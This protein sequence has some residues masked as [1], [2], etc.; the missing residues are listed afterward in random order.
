MGG[1]EG[2]VIVFQDG[3][4]IYRFEKVATTNF[5]TTQTIEKWMITAYA[6][7]VSPNP[8]QFYVDDVTIST[9]RLKAWQ[10]N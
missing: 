2:Q 10:E 7:T 9:I 8:F 3:K 1:G 4:E 5:T 6:N